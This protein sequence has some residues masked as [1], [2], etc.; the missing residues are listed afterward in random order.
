[1]SSDDSPD[2]RK[3]IFFLYELSSELEEELVRRAREN[4]RS[5]STEATEIIERHV[6]EDGPD[7]N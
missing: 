4:G 5:P 7:D 1:M 2:P 3:E 6:E